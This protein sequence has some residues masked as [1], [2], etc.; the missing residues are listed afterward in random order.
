M[1][2]DDLNTLILCSFRYA[3][4]RIGAISEEVAELILKHAAELL[5][6]TKQIIIREISMCLGRQTIGMPIDKKLWMSVSERLE[7]D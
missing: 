1:T 6:E 2:K 3:I 4:G 7:N 5:Q